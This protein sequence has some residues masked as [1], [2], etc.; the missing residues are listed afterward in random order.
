VNRDYTKAWN[1]LCS[2]EKL[3]LDSEDVRFQK[4][5]REY[6]VLFM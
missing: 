4:Y 6:P 3:V 1:I 2:V 5:Q